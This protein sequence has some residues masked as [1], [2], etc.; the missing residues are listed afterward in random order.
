M[1]NWCNNY[2]SF[3]HKDPEQIKKLIAASKEGKLFETFVPFP[4]GEWDYGWAVENWGTKWDISNSDVQETGDKDAS[5]SFDSAWGPPVAFYR[6]MTEL[7]FDVDATYYE[8]GMQFAGHYTSEDDDYCYEYDFENNPDWREEVEDEDVKDI[9]EGLYESW[10]DW[11]E[12][13]E[14]EDDSE[15]TESDEKRD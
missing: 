7:G 11:Q 13:N 15:E 1:P 6:K 5:V 3:S 10:Q 9:L 12:M 4:N 8:E 2:A 14:E